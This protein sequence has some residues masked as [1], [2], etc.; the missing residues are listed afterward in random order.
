MAERDEWRRPFYDEEGKRHVR[1]GAPGGF[2][3]RGRT[4]EYRQESTRQLIQDFLAEAQTL[5]R[6]EIILAK[7]ELRADVR[8]ASRGAG[9]IGVGGAM[10]YAGMLCLV[11]F[12][13]ALLSLAMKVWVAALLV[14]LVVVGVGAML[15]MDGRSKLKDARPEDFPR[16]MKENREWASTTMR[17]VRSNRR[18]HA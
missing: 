9:L 2:L 5:A 15:A 6:S 7:E 17:D 12:L 18:V 13:V 3:E 1:F 10:L 4:G 16:S 11:G 14:G 8:E